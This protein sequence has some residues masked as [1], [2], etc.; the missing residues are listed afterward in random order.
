MI[1]VF[2]KSFC[3]L[4]A[5]LCACALSASSPDG[6]PQEL[7]EQSDA[8]LLETLE[9]G[10]RLWLSEVSFQCS[11]TLSKGNAS[12]LSDAQGGILVNR[13]LLYTGHIYKLGDAVRM[14]IKYEGGPID[15]SDAKDGSQ[16]INVSSDEMANGVISVSYIPKLVKDP[17]TVVVGEQGPSNPN[18]ISAG[19]R[20]EDRCGPLHIFGASRGTPF[21]MTNLVPEGSNITNTATLVDNDH[22]EVVFTYS[23][24]EWTE[25]RRLLFWLTPSP[26]V[27]VKT[28]LKQ[29][30]QQGEGPSYYE[31]TSEY[32]KCNGG[33]VPRIV[34]CVT[35]SGDGMYQVQ[36]FIADGLGDGPPSKSDFVMNIPESVLLYGL[37]GVPTVG[38]QRQIALFEIDLSDL[39]SSVRPNSPI[40]NPEQ[41]NGIAWRS[42]LIG[43]NI[44]FVLVIV[45]VIFVVKR[46]TRTR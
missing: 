10:V 18:A 7:D 41:E 25:E 26:P 15:V 39:G 5:C 16:V 9:A 2:R 33:M 29:R 1:T 40:L 12:S 42:W 43:L 20:S 37:E 3:I 23:G 31:F 30:N 36:E 4:L 28:S 44:A 21:R 24:T 13:N 17:G 38:G 8:V 22:V 45:T 34:R 11:Y 46:R 6:G 32:T 14:S 19:S 27:I 35:N